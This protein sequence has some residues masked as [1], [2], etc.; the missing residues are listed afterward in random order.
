MTVL[1]LMIMTMMIKND[2]CLQFVKIFSPS[3]TNDKNCIWLNY[4]DRY[5]A[6]YV[7]KEK[8]IIKK[9]SAKQAFNIAF[10]QDSN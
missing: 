3:I 9:N 6:K 10:V 8:I 1:K 4:E 7:S 2:H 5:I